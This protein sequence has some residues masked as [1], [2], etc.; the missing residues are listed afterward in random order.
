MAE[1]LPINDSEDEDPYFLPNVDASGV[2]S[3]TREVV[4]QGEYVWINN[5]ALELLARE[6]IQQSREN[7]PP[8]TW[9]DQYHFYDGTERTANW[10]L[11]LDA[12][13]FCF[14]A[15]KNQPRWSIA[16]QGETLNGYLAEAAA[17]K[18]AVEEDIPLWEA[19]YLS[20]ISCKELAHIFRGEQTIPL[21]EQRLDNLHEVGHVLLERYNGQFI[22]AIEQAEHNAVQLVLLLAENFSSFN[23]VVFYRDRQ[24]R[25]FKRAQI[26]VADLHGS[27]GGK[28]WGAFSA[29][30][31][32][33]AFADYKLP[34]V[35]R[36]FGVL[37]Y[38][39]SLAER[40]DNQEL[41]ESGSEEE[42]ELRAA[43]IWACELLRREMISQDRPVTA[44]EID[45]RLWLTGQIQSNMRPY[46]RTRSMYY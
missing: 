28:S 18:R 32:L 1:V 37:E 14:W 42:V 19:Q 41:L 12:M 33:T 2:L 31:Q 40:I 39:P 46:H 26:C 22:N 10:I 27:F 3:S 43:T 34:Q 21:L 44:A 24:V 36:H 20:N 16:Y 13:N 38:H 4:E 45:L 8:P 6:W 17:L 25:F 30:D 7:T 9:Y 29:L 35:L 15:E 5:D 23:D 11:A